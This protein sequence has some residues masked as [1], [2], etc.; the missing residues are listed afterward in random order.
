MLEFA[1]E[2]FVIIGIMNRM[3]F[4]AFCAFRC[5]DA[6]HRSIVFLKNIAINKHGNA[7]SQPPLKFEIPPNVTSSPK[8]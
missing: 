7:E 6:S 8:K 1:F 4:D 2:F 3:L 5:H